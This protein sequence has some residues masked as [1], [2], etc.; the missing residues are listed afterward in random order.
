MASVMQD[1]EFSAKVRPYL[2]W[3]LRQ[4]V[5]QKT[6][7]PKSKRAVQEKLNVLNNHLFTE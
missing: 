7:L 1:P 4:N 3:H 6:E 2:L 5:P